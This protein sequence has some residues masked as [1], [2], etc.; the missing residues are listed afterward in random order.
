MRGWLVGVAALGMLAATG[1]AGAAGQTRGPGGVASYRMATGA[2]AV[3]GS[4]SAGR[5]PLLRPGARTY[6]DS[7][8]PG[9]RKYYTVEL[10]AESS[11]YVSAVAVPRPGSTMGTR[12]GIDVALEAMDGS[13]C[14]AGRHRTF[15]SAGGAYPIADY[16]ERVVRTGGSCKEAGT[17]RFAVE[18]GDAAG[19]DSAAVPVELKYAT[20]PADRADGLTASGGWSS[21]APSAPGEP[22]TAVVG[23]SGFNDAAELRPGAWRDEL[24]PGETR[25][26]QVS[27]GAGRQLFA[28][29]RFAGAPGAAASPYVISG[30][31]MGLSNAARGHVMNKTAGYQGKEATLSLATPPVTPGGGAGGDAVRGMRLAGTY[32]LQV[33]LNAKVAKGA[34]DAVPVT[35]HIGVSDARKAVAE[36]RAAGSLPTAAGGGS[37]GRLRLIGYA[38]VGTGSLLLLGLGGWTLAA[39]RSGG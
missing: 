19:G 34:S 2:Q 28:D 17:Y 5:G 4:E 27:V 6:T 7:I 16:A 3:R 37:D 13:P 30:V 36:R 32:Y 10:D 12:D 23:G 11:A 18:R 29:A 25:F 22:S 33:S 26:Y 15:L 9:E 14:G 1:N 8:K 38:G 21:R 31:R 24:R 20:G 35:L 39:R